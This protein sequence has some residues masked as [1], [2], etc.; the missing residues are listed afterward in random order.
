MLIFL[1]LQ[2]T[3]IASEDVICAISLLYKEEL[4]AEFINEGKKIPA[5]ASSIH[6]ITNEMISE[7]KAFKESKSFKILQQYN[8]DENTL[9]MHNAPFFLEKLLS[10]SFSWKGAVVDTS[11]VCKHLIPECEFF[12]LHFLRYELQLY[13][14]EEVLKNKY[15]IAYVLVAHDVKSDVIITKLLFEYL[16]EMVSLEKMQELSFSKV[17]LEKV[18]FGKYQGRYIEEIMQMD[19]SY[20]QWMLQLDDLDEDLRYSLQYYLEGEI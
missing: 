1:D 3:G 19:R 7:G 2:T 6:N 14:E 11:R 15:G 5:L 17:L 13:R 20:L 8:S 18:P 10:H 12:S 4:V 9:V 16:Q